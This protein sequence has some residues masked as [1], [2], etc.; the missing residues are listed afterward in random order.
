MESAEFSQLL[1]QYQ[2]KLQEAEQLFLSSKKLNLQTFEWIQKEK[3]NRKLRSLITWKWVAILLGLVWVVFLLY[4]V[5][6]TFHWERI[7]YNI[8]ASG[9]ALITLIAMIIYIYHLV[10]LNKINHGNTV[11]AT[12]QTIVKLKSSTLLVTRILF[13]QSVFY[14]TFWWNLKMIQEA[15]F[16]FWFISFPI[17]LVFLL[18]SLWLFKNISFKNSGKKWFRIL[19]NSPEWQRLNEAAKYL[20][21]PAETIIV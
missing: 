12:Q 16:S 20:N 10:L 9:I 15:P 7:F 4:T 11:L 2:Q 14:C 1:N 18:A 17:A 13:L 8:S 3:S 5:T 6:Y 19:F 21:D